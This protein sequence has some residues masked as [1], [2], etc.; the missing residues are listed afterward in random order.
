MRPY[1]VPSHRNLVRTATGLMVPGGPRLAYAASMRDV[2]RN[3]PVAAARGK[4]IPPAAAGNGLLTG[5]TAYWKM[6]E[7]T[8]ANRADSSGNGYTLTDVGTL[9]SGTG[10]INNAI[11]NTADNTKY[12]SRAIESAFLPGAGSFTC[13]GWFRTTDN[14][15]DQ[16]IISVGSGTAA[17]NSWVVLYSNGDAQHL[18]GAISQNGTNN[19]EKRSEAAIAN[20]TW[21]FFAFWFDPAATSIY[22]QVNNGTI[23]S[24]TNA[25]FSAV[26]DSVRPLI[27]GCTDPL[28][29]YGPL[30]GLVDEVGWWKGRILTTAQLTALYNGGAALPFASFTA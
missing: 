14:T 18:K 30:K 7:S 29:G 13:T 22:F 16:W 23:Y 4:G 2:A 3:Y 27:V 21:Y 17:A 19:L 5:L 28:N 25:T 9:A 10:I 24:A 26:Y 6:D 15:V 8:G 1:V 11:S 20:N 12:L